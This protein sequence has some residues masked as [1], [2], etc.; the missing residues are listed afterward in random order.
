MEFGTVEKVVIGAK[1]FS[2]EGLELLRQA[3]R[4][5]AD[6]VEVEAVSSVYR[7]TGASERTDHIHDLRSFAVFDGMVLAVI[8]RC[9]LAP[10]ELG[11]RLRQIEGKY[12]SEALRRSVNL[13]LF[14]FGTQTLM[15]PLLT[16]PNPEF[17]LKAENVL[18]V[19]EIFPDFVHP[20]L[21][22]TVR[23]LGRAHSGQPWGEFVAQGKAMLDF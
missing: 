2:S 14:F 20:V 11:E 23:S 15:T 16:L 6:H 12:R 22:Q 10:A 18:P 21:H 4:A 5:L 7:V 8:G 1:A 9:A 17:H 3:L 19:A 13:D